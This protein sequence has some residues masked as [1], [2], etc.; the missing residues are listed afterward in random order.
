MKINSI[1]KI[2]EIYAEK[3]KLDLQVSKKIFEKIL[4]RV[5]SNSDRKL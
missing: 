5:F 2:F 1:Y 4:K 3:N